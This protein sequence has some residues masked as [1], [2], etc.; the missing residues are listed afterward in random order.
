MLRL[1]R[2]AVLTFQRQ[3]RAATGMA[4]K[5]Y[6]P[7]R[8]RCQRCEPG[9]RRRHP[10][11]HALLQADSFQPT[12]LNPLDKSLHLL[13]HA[14][15]RLL[16]CGPSYRNACEQL[17]FFALGSWTGEKWEEVVQRFVVKLK[18]E[19]GKGGVEEDLRRVRRECGEAVRVL[20]REGE[21]EFER[22]A[23]DLREVVRG[24]GLG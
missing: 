5:H 20:E 19:G 17:R 11:T 4:S 3:W 1:R 24:C 23:G 18:G 14:S 13:A 15:A 12:R 21:G 6:C 16:R 7:T 9:R 22:D 8:Q 2:D 10:R